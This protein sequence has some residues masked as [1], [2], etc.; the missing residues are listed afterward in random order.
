MVENVL[1][2]LAS[3]FRIFLSSMSISPKNPEKVVLASWVLHNYLRLKIPLR[4]TPN[5]SFEKVHSENE[6][7]Q[8]G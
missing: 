1:G 5:F 8:P 7:V 4:Y 3:R 6:A 2:I